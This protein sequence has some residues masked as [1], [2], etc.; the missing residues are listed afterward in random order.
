MSRT[1]PPPPRRPSP[2]RP[3]L[4]GKRQQPR[5]QGLGA[6]AASTVKLYANATCT[7]APLG[8]GTA[9]AFNT[10]AGIT[11]TV[12]ADSTTNLR[13]TATDAAGNVSA[14]STALP[15]SRTRPPRSLPP[16]SATSPAS[17]ANDNSPGSAA[18]PRPPRRCAS[19]TTPPAPAP[20]LPAGLRRR[21]HTAPG[22]PSR[23]PTTRPPACAPPPPTPP[24]TSPPARRHVTYVEDS[25]APATPTVNS[26]TPA[27]PAN[28]NNPEVKGSGAEAGATVTSTTTP[29]CTGTPLGAGTAAA[30]NTG[31]G[32]T[33]T[34]AAD[35]TTNLRAAV[36]DD[37]GN[38]SPCSNAIA[39]V[40]DSSAPAS[41]QV[42]STDPASP[43]D[44]NNPEVIGSAEAGSTVRLYKGSGCTDPPPHTASAS[45]FA[46][47]GFT[48]SVP[49]DSTT[50]L[51][52]TATDAAGNV[53][54]CSTALDLRRGL[55]RPGRS[56]AQR[57]QPRLARKR[58]QPR[59]QR[60]GRGR[61][62]GA[63]LRQRH[64]HRPPAC[65]RPRRRLQRR[66]DH[67][68]RCPTTR[69][70]ACARP[71]P[72][73]QATPRRVP[74]RSPISRTRRSPP[75]RPSP[76]TAPP[77]RQTTTTPRSRAR[78]RGRRDGQHLRQRH[79]H[80]HPA[81]RGHGRRLQHRRRDHGHG[82]GRL[83]H[84]PARRGQRRRRQRLAVF[85]RDRLRRGLQRPGVAPGR[86][87][88]PRLARRR[89]QPRGDRLGRSGLDRAPLQG[90]RLH[91]SAGAHRLGLELCLA[92]LH[93]LGPRRL[94]HQPARH[95]HRRRRQ[96]LR[97]LD[98]AR[99]RRGLDRPGR[100]DASAPP[101]P[102]SPANDNSPELSGSAEAASTVRIYDNATCTGPPLAERHRRRLQRRR[103]HASRCPTTRPPACAPRPPTRQA[104]PRRV[105]TRSPISRTRPIPAS[106][107]R[108]LDH[109]PP[110]PQ[111]TTTPRSRA[112]RRGRLDGAASTTTPPAPA[113]RWA[114]APPPP[115]TPAPGSRPRSPPDSTTNLRAAVTDD[116]GN[117]SPCSNAI[118]YVED[119]SAPAAPEVDSTPTPTRPPTTTTPR[120]TARPKRARPCASTRAPAAPI[121]RAHRLGLELR[122]ARAS[123]SRCPTTRPPTCAPRPPTPPATSPPARRRSPTSRTRPPRSL[124]PSAP[125]TPPRPQTTTA[126]SSRARPR[127][128]RRCASTTTPPAPA[129]ACHRHRRRLQRRRDH[130]SRCPTTR[131]PACAPPPPTP[132]GNAS[133]CSQRDLLSSRTRRSPRRPDRHR[134]RP[135]LAGKRQQP[136]GQGLGAEAGSTVEIYDN[137]ACTGTPLATGSAAAFNG[138]G[139]HGHGRRRT[140]PPTCAPPP[141]TPPATSP[142]ARRRSPTS[143]T[144][145]PRRRRRHRHRPA[146]RPT[147]TTPRSRARRRGRLDGEALH[148]RRPARAR[149]WPP[150]PPP[151]SHGA[152]ITVTVAGRLDHQPARD[153]HRRRRQRLGLLGRARLRRGLDRPGAPTRHRHRAPLARERQQPRGQGLG[154]GRSTGAHLRQRRPAPAPAGHRLRRH[155]QRRRDHRLGA[156]RLD[157]QPPRHRHRR[158]PAT[159]RRA[160]TRSPTSRTRRPPPPRP[161]PTPPA[162]A[163]KRQQ[164]RG[165]GHGAEAQLDGEDL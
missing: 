47:P 94:D 155:L 151:P 75:P 33:A 79:L 49:D 61:L 45:S 131:P 11:A 12:A 106:S 137:A 53:S 129:P 125:P 59:A 28:D 135:R 24:A 72:T 120:S 104:T 67:A 145:P 161:S 32:I 70:P 46:S 82:R 48:I 6:E 39:Y 110:R 121:R 124:R 118:A 98:G 78:R 50:N 3:R 148:E 63:H 8:S 84:Q 21:L 16:L 77:R 152:G 65:Q 25:T 83:D 31:A 149:R 114:R 139:D 138:A 15:T 157:H 93:D 86:L 30:F 19:M 76:T 102:A 18:R 154:R 113:P 42:D 140:R 44:E 5:G 74:T 146:R 87:H 105:P 109:A 95:G 134:H 101:D 97:L 133:P 43:A 51:R 147:T 14:C 37:A 34:V 54:G 130:A 159:S 163:R 26:T 27:S 116:A 20:R 66:R 35:S 92:R 115:S 144:R 81:G 13:A 142:A 141:P 143:R 126:P 119:S 62:D 108:R 162:L 10:G 58:Q 1:R 17:P 132:A 73:R 88:R 38:A 57:H 164:P 60:L 122:L 9:A 80:R 89:E 68:S 123:R 85:Q 69:P 91:R 90:L 29:T 99:L 153:G 22:S 111:T 41:P 96:R 2:P 7:G 158:R 55:D 160:P 56:D 165:Q 128:P 52:A 100:S 36:K 4:A 103:D 112:R 64:L 107:D 150:A 71:P 136:R 156:R 40:E 127:P 117:A 23:C